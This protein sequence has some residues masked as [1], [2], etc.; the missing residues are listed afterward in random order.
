MRNEMMAAMYYGPQDLRIE[1][2]P[3]PPLAPDGILLQIGAATTCGT[4]AKIF[5][6]GYPDLPGLPLPFGHECAGVVAAVGPEVVGV[7]V[8]ERVVAGIAAPCGRC[9]WCARSQPVF[10]SDRTY[11]IP[12]GAMPGG[13]YAEYIAVPGAIVRGNLH[14]IPDTL[15]FAEAA[16]VEPL[17]CALYGIEELP[18][19]RIGDTVAINGDGPLG[20]FFLRLAKLRGAS[21]VVSGKV[22]FRLEKARRMGADAIIDIRQVDDQIR[23]V[24][25]VIGAPGPDVVI[26]ATGLPQVWELSV[27]MARRGGSVLLFG[28]CPGG[29]TVTLDTRKI[30]YDCLT[31]KSPSVYLQTPDMLARC[32]KLLAHGDVPGREF[33]TGRGP[34]SEALHLLQRHIQG[35]GLKFEIVPP[36]FWTA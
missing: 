28:G 6:R 26:E 5:R 21:V 22:P 27:N 36:A 24:Y 17:A 19:I 30:H 33:I 31:I 11:L 35:E 18:E 15:S 25:E 23:A 20:L 4:D 8:G 16:L 3:I 7:E 1:D 14:R 34:L 10:C 12:G 2:V 32:L 9:Y 13:A 29:S